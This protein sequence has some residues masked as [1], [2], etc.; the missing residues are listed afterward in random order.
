MSRHRNVRSMNYEDEY[1]DEDDMYGHSV[2][3]NYCI[4]PG[5]AAQFTFNRERNVALSNYMDEQGGIPEEDEG[6]DTDEGTPR[7]QHRSSLDYT[8]PKLTDV[9]EA[10]LNS[11]LEEV[12]NVI[13][14]AVP[15][16]VMVD[17]IMKHNFSVEGSLNELLNQQEAPKPQREPR[18]ERRNRSQG[19]ANTESSKNLPTAFVT[20]PSPTVILKEPPKQRVNDTNSVKT[21]NVTTANNV[22]QTTKLSSEPVPL[23]TQI[24]N[25]SVNSKDNRN[26][27]SSVTSEPVKGSKVSDIPDGSKGDFNSEKSSKDTLNV[28]KATESKDQLSTPKKERFIPPL[29]KSS[30]KQKTEKYDLKE[31]YKKRAVGKDMLNMVVIGH[32]DAGKSTLMGHLLYQLGNVNQ[33]AMHKYEQESKKLGKSS[34][35]YAWVLDETEEER[36]R[37]VTMDIAQTKFETTQKIITLLDAPGHKDFI[38]NMIT[39]TAQADVA[40]LVVNATKGEFE[41]GFESGGQT[42]EHALLARSL[43]VSQ[44]IVAVN[45]MDTVGWDPARYDDV[46]RKLGQFLKQAGFK[47]GDTSFIPVSGLGGENLARP[48]KEPQLAAWY[49]GN[50]LMEQIDKFKPVA[51]PV[52]KPLRITVSDVFKGMGS[53]YTVTGKVVSGSVQ[54]GDRVTVMPANEYAM[55]KG[56]GINDEAVN[57]AF[58]GDSVS[59]VITGIDITHVSVGSVL[60]DSNNPVICATR[61]LARVVLFNLEVPITRGFTVIFH[62]QTMSEPAIVKKLVS[63]LNKSTGEV[64]KNKPKCLTKNSSAVIELEYERPVCLELYKDNKELGRFMLRS[65]GHTIAAGLVEGVLKTK[66]GYVGEEGQL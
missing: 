56:I 28:D 46:V 25:Q 18:R 34:F 15:E 22:N 41:T 12:R 26:T 57:Y 50:N 65:S 62:Y 14:E 48:V 36:A 37:G 54:I 16:G 20:G 53:G 9:D 61:I 40:V 17:T 32:V 63:Q 64:V 42:R 7:T 21:S 1:Y 23:K 45:K 35:A 52:D 6:D 44:I 43:G 8:R 24:N 3:D 4:S 47:E 19:N 5:T 33:R 55:V 11:V 27:T 29:P 2:E 49:K 59:V 66:T 10:K 30:S 39:G 60:C 58:A 31:E 51:R 38:P 13:G